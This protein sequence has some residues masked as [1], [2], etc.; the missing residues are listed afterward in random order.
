MAKLGILP[1]LDDMF[2]PG[3]QRLLDQMPFDGAYAMRVQSLRGLLE[4]Y[5]REL[6]M[7]TR[8]L[9]H[10]LA[11]H[12]GY[13]AIQAVQG[14]GPI[15]AAIFVAEIG[16]VTRF[17]DARHLCSWAGL[18]PP[19]GSPTPT[20]NAATSR[21]RGATWC[22]GRPSKPSL[23]TTVATPSPRRSRGSPNGGA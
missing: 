19:T 3:G 1:T 10:R 16:D 21:S 13:Q 8:E 22:A 23:A 5:E 12:Q 20:S 11:H 18:T 9:H 7:V 4:I 15:M 14:I 17:P 6:G 2:G